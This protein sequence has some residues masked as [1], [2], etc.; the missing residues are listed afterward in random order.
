MDSLGTWHAQLA[1]HVLHSVKC[2]VAYVKV[3][4]DHYLLAE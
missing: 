4:Q 1:L 3:A 2:T